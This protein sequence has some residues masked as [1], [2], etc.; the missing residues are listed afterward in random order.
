MKCERCQ[1]NA[2]T[3]AV[4]AEKDGKPCELF[5]CDAC[6]R[7]THKVTGTVSLADILFSLGAPGDA[8]PA[9]PPAD[10]KAGVVQDAV[11]TV[12]A[13]PAC[14]MTRDTLRDRRRFGCPVCY[15]T[16]VDDVHALLRE[17][18]YGDAHVGRTPRKAALKRRMAMLQASLA[19]AIAAQQYEA[20]ATLR[21][22]IKALES[23]HSADKEYP[24]GEA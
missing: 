22:Q 5:V 6:A 20:A 23:V 16:F 3:Q 4:R 1:R 13:C 17:L 8:N 24:H 18:Q 2:A 10:A 19:Q 15:D 21:D 12:A 11:A 7:E 14:G 9:P